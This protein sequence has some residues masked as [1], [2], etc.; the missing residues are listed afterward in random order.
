MIE[1]V[2]VEDIEAYRYRNTVCGLWAG[3]EKWLS[4]KVKTGE[5]KLAT[6][7]CK[8]AGTSIL[9]SDTRGTWQCMFVVFLEVL[10]P[11]SLFLSGLVLPLLTG[12][13][14]TTKQPVFSQPFFCQFQA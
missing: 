4:Y 7:I 3:F 10:F 5:Y 12:T 13:Q 1:S 8:L 14:M 6:R 11:T 2:V 9:Y